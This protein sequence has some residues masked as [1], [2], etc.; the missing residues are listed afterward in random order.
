[1]NGRS[2]VGKLRQGLLTSRVHSDVFI[3]TWILITAMIDTSS[4]ITQSLKR[5]ARRL[6]KSRSP[7]VQKYSTALFYCFPSTSNSN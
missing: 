4:L 7:T 1:M 5:S 6:F 2:G 3:V